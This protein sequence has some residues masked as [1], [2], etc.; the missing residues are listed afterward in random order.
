MKTYRNLT[1]QVALA[2]CLL[3]ISGCMSFAY[4][5]E[6]E[7]DNEIDHDMPDQPAAEVASCMDT[8][9]HDPKSGV[10][11]LGGRPLYCENRLAGGGFRLVSARRS[12][13]GAL[14]GEETCLSPEQSCSG[15]LTED[16]VAVGE[17]T[18]LLASADRAYWLHIASNSVFDDFLTRR[19]ALEEGNF[20]HG[21]HF[22]NVLPEPL[23]IISHSANFQ[24]AADEIASLWLTSGG[25]GLTG[26]KGEM[27][28]AFN[29][30]PYYGQSGA[31]FLYGD[32]GQGPVLNGVP[33]A[34]FYR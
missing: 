20:C 9:T 30:A 23:A 32:D 31:L 13:E 17:G 18:L 8:M 2:A 24:P 1:V 6:D 19:R 26:P 15:S 11:A 16:E 14:F 22:C 7:I 34:L 25:V 10:Y 5:M 28:G 27:I 33:G 4:E 12:D 21:Q 29:L 3:T